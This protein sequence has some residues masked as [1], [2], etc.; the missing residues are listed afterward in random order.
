MNQM[1]NKV[2]V[3]PQGTMKGPDIGESEMDQRMMTYTAKV[4]NRA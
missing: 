1:A 4:E 2:A 3:E